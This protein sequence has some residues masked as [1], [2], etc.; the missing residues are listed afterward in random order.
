[1]K[2][3]LLLLS[4]FT[5][6]VS[7]VYATNYHCTYQENNTYY[8][9]GYKSGDT[10]DTYCKHYKGSDFWKKEYDKCIKEDFPRAQRA[11]KAGACKK[12][13]PPKVYNNVEGCT[14]EVSYLEGSDSPYSRS[15]YSKGS[16]NCNTNK[17]MKKLE[18]M[19]AK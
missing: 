3:I 16:S 9:F 2:K 13:L 8:S 11:F 5:L 4:V 12:E 1:M 18:W 17:A 7:V 15:C 14:C 10:V 19:L 6:S